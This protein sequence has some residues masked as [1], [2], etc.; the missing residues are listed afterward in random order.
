MKRFLEVQAAIDAWPECTDVQA[1]ANRTVDAI[2]N[3]GGST[4]SADLVGLVRQELRGIHGR[5]ATAHP[6]MVPR[7]DPWPSEEAWRR[8]GISAHPSGDRFSLRAEPWAPRWLPDVGD[9]GVDLYAM[10]AERR[11][12]SERVIGDPFLT[13]L[14]PNISTYLTAGQRQAVRT[15]LSTPPDTTIVVNLPTGSGK[16][17]AAIAPALLNRDV[18][19]T[20]VVVPTTTLALDHERRLA[21]QLGRPSDRATFAYH[22]GLSS[23][24]RE[25]LRSEFRSGETPVLFT[26]PESLVG[27]L[28][29]TLDEVARN[30]Q[31]GYFVVDEAHIVSEWGDEFRPEFQAMAGIRRHLRRRMLD[32]GCPPFRTVLMT[33]TLTEATLETLRTI[34]TDDEGQSESVSSVMIRPEPAYWIAE[35]ASTAD[36]R[37]ERLLD[38]VANLPRPLLVYTTLVKPQS[39]RSGALSTVEVERLLRSAGYRRLTRVDGSTSPRARRKAMAGLRGDP[40]RGVA[41]SL[42]IVVASSAFGLGVDI[43]DIRTVIHACIPETIDRYYQEVGRAGRDGRA[44]VS[45]LIPGPDDHETARG[46][47]QRKMISADRGW[48][49]W[50]SMWQAIAPADDLGES[51]YRLH[52]M[53]R[54]PGIKV[55]ESDYNEAWN[56]RTLSVMARARMIRFD[57]EA[58]PR[59]EPPR[60]TDQQA[61]AALTADETPKEFDDYLNSVII[62]LRKG[63]LDEPS[64]RTSFERIRTATNHQNRRSLELMEEVL[65]GR[66][67]VGEIFADAYAIAP[68]S[69]YGRVIPTASCGGCPACRRAGQSPYQVG[70]PIPG[71]ARHPVADVDPS[72]RNLASPTDAGEFLLVTV[73]PR[74]ADLQR[75]I[76]QLLKRLA[77]LGVRQLLAADQKWL[78][79]PGVGEANALAPEGFFFVG[80]LNDPSAP[81]LPTVVIGNLTDDA[82]TASIRDVSAG[83]FPLK[84]SL[85]SRDCRDPDK[86]NVALRELRPCY[87]LDDLLERI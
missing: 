37:N 22:G 49:R 3:L 38:A 51:R 21:E 77:P 20:V 54:P 80:D 8:S 66:R 25:R 63:D 6:L 44:S 71:P 14:D 79:V 46:L 81:R 9:S 40:D 11:R 5:T 78:T 16:T 69:G 15:V 72:L 86:P 50:Q 74:R 67:C 60:Q 41:T 47:N 1:G 29:W 24:E 2:A 27:S 48:E 19:R 61:T 64:W 56:L 84:V 68:D 7:T 42:D 13:K 85:L 34:F 76:S 28:S 23:D 45:I 53:A 4:G 83:G 39:Y 32:A 18:A 10:R 58:P 55:G 52:L 36:E 43:S 59:S 73:D 62:E 12:P 65:R 33:G 57:A 30:G 26:S 70:S 82:S 35:D 17:L 31:L 75:R 87:T